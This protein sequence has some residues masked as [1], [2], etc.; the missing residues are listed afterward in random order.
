MKTLLYTAFVVGLTLFSMNLQAQSNKCATMQI[1]EQRMK[2]D[3]S[4]Q[5]RM[6]QS[7]I[8]TQKWISANRNAK[9]GT[10]TGEHSS[11]ST[12]NIQ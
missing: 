6:Q 10:N 8:E 3:P 12:R 1:L 11:R 7:E 2:K 5:L 4:I 9:K